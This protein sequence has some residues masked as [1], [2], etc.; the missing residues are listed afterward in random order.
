MRKLIDTDL[1]MWAIVA[2]SAACLIGTA[3]AYR[4]IV[5]PEPEP[6]IDRVVQSPPAPPLP[7][8]LT[9]QQRINEAWE[10]MKLH[11]EGYR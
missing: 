1:K 11:R 5:A 7:V 4:A 2:A 6:Q 9:P 3:F 10:A 8:G